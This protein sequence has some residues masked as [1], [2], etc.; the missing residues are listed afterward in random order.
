MTFGTD[1]L[2]PVPFDE[3]L[4]LGKSEHAEIRDGW[5]ARE[6]DIPLLRA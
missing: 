5:N 1:G 3:M 6:M 2:K 4:S